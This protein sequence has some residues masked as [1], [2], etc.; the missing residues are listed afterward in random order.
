[1]IAL[2]TSEQMMTMEEQEEPVRPGNQLV[3]VA[4]V[5][6]RWTAEA[7]ISIS[8]ISGGVYTGTTYNMSVTVSRTGSTVFGLGCEA[9]FAKHQCRNI[10]YPPC[11]DTIE[12]CYS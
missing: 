11:T 9:L 10:G 12:E 4:M 3:W 1:M 2:F 7:S 5:I 6:S 8:G